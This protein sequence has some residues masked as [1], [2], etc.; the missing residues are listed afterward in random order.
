MITSRTYAQTLDTQ[1]PLAH[2]RDR[3]VFTDKNLIYLDGNSLGRLPKITADLS[4]DLIHHQWGE[5][6][7]RSWHESGWWEAPERIGG[8]IARLIG[9]DP[10]EVIIADSTSTNLF[11]LAVAAL[12]LQAERPHIV[13]DDL[14][15]PSDHY[16]LQGIIDTL[17]NRHQL[18]VVNS[19]DGIHGADF[20]AM[21]TEQTALLT[22]SHIVF[23]GGFIY[24][25]TAVSAQAHAVGALTLWD[26][27]HSAGS[28][29][30]DVHEAN[31]D[32]A[33][34]CTYKYLNG[35]PGA[36][37]FLYVRRD[38]QEK[39]F[40]PLSGW[41]GQHNPFEFGLGYQ[42]TPSLRHFL[43]GT[44]PMAS[45]ALIEPGVDLLLEAGM[46][47]L[48]AKSA[49]QTAYL[50]D[51]WE[52]WLQPLG[53]TLNSPRLAS[54]RGSHVSVGHPEGWRINR[55]LIDK[56]HVLPDFRTPDNIRLGIAP[57][58]T[59]F[60]DIYEAMSRL[61]H[62]VKSGLYLEVDATEKPTVT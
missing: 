59:T 22:L 20:P 56:M 54:V 62:V 24:D 1:D 31:I 48:R 6:L 44:P 35:G 16:I 45:L 15:F 32:L 37:A 10:D 57:I 33:V 58:Y 29:E 14:N 52:A 2:F 47:R 11:K 17:G 46:D 36:P 7:I 8:K 19:V 12:R 4:A 53:F 41:I 5:R 51:L 38:L 9:A 61:R 27:S 43:T 34:G 28:V 40:N 26:M 50:I 3:F 39:L 25:L 60:E 13:T 42:P 30:M 55:A 49:A 23:K 21:L 18:R